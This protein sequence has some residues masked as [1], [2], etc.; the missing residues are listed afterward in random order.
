MPLLDGLLSDGS[1]NSGDVQRSP[2][3]A[4]VLVLAV[5]DDRAREAVVDAQGEVLLD[6][7]ELNGVVVAVGQ[8]LVAEHGAHGVVADVVGDANSSS[9]ELDSLV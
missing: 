8:Q 1:R 2:A 7:Q 9:E 4:E 3:D 6:R 5:V